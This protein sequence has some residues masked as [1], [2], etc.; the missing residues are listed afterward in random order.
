[1]KEWIPILLLVVGGALTSSCGVFKDVPI[2]QIVAE[3]SGKGAEWL[4]SEQGQAY[5]KTVIERYAPGVDPALLGGGLGSIGAAV[6]LM[7]R[8]M[9]SKG[10]KDSRKRK[11]VWEAIES[12]KSKDK[13]S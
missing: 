12:L 13:P 7:I 10:S 4:Q 3:A 6:L 9:M 2:D 8:N 11:E 5:L 1:M